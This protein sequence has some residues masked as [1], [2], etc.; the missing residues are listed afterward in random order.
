V[1]RFLRLKASWQEK[2]LQDMTKNTIIFVDEP[3]L[4]SLGSAFVSISGERVVSL[5]GEVLCGIEGI[6]GVHCCGS[7][8]WSLMLGLP[9]DIVS[10]DAYNYYQSL[11][12]Y[13]D[14][15]KAFLHRGGTIAWGIVPNDEEMLVKE[16]VASLG[17]RLGEAVAPFTRDGVSYR[18]VLEQSLVTPSC[19]LA[20]L[21]S[22]A[23]DQVLALLAGL[24]GKLRQRL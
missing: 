3:Y 12:L 17:D 19:G 20:S 10:F 18:T 23:A 5:I 14:D 7:T 1:A 15:V 9:T 8:D 6:S 2:F 21:S 16:T 4:T 13:P 24:S 11:S 22:E